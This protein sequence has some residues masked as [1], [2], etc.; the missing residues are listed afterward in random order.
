MKQFRIENEVFSIFPHLE[1]GI[2]TL[3]GM[4]NS[5]PCPEA[6]AGLARA[7]E[8]LGARLAAAGGTLPEVQTFADAMKRIVRKKGCRASLDAMARRIAKGER[9]GSINPAV[10]IY[11]TVS[12]THCFTCG[13]ENL[14]RIQGDM[15]LGLASGEEPFVPLGETENAPPRPGELV[16]RDDGGIVVRSWVWREAD[17]TKLDGEAR[18]VLL[19]MENIDPERSGQ[20]QAALDDLYQRAALL[21]GE[22]TRQV[23]SAHN[24]A[25]A[26]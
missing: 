15:V 9:I 5:R 18:D 1:I 12:L 21:G 25:C 16:Y 24:P 6:A 4:D 7:C 13:G 26:L 20:L 22:R 10:D 14:A 19:Y 3:R 23:I 8:A 2:V 11:N 17:R